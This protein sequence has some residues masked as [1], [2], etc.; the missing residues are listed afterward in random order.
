M[1]GCSKAYAM[2]GWR[3]GF[4]GAPVALIKA[5]DKLQ[6]QS[7]SNASSVSQA[8]ALAA[9]EGRRMGWRRWPKPIRARR[10]FVVSALN[11]IAG[12]SC[13]RPEGA[14]YVFPGM[15]GCIGKTSAGGVRIDDDEAFVCAAGGAGRSGGARR[16]VH[17]PGHFRVSYATDMESLREACARIAV[18]CAGLK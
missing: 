2:T 3:I 7:T 12:L 15:Q 11:G 10:D 6:S 18:F 5:M 17:V 13:H 4:A 1:N 8:A 16:G 14:F 9:L